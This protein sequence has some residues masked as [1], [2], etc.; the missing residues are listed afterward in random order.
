AASAEPLHRARDGAGDFLDWI[1][2]V[3]LL[4]ANLDEARA[5]A[6]TAPTGAD[7]ADDLA[8]KLRAA[9]AHVVIKLGERGA[10]WAGPHGVT[11]QPGQAA[12][13]VDPTGAGDAFAAGFLDA[14]LSGA[15]PLELAVAL[16]AAAVG[17]LGGRPAPAN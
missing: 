15:P 1:R 11:R 2:G 5:L 16:G 8:R 10:L 12:T 14:W 6:G 3:D 13:V 4:F 9:A 17:I 7:E